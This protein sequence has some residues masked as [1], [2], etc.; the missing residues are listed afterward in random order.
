[1]Q[2]QL[3]QDLQNA[4]ALNSARFNRRILDVLN[5]ENKAHE[6]ALAAVLKERWRDIREG[7]AALTFGELAAVLGELQG[8]GLPISPEKA[9]PPKA[10]GGATPFSQQGF[11]DALRAR[12]LT[13]EGLVL[14]L[15]NLYQ[16]QQDK[17][18][19]LSR[20]FNIFASRDPV[21]KALENIEAFDAH[22]RKNGVVFNE[23]ERDL[24]QGAKPKSIGDIIIELRFA[25]AAAG[26]IALGLAGVDLAQAPLLSETPGL[27]FSTGLP[28]FAGA[29]IGLNIFKAF[30]EYSIVKESSTL[31][32]FAAIT[33]AGFAVSYLAVAGMTGLFPPGDGGAIKEIITEG[34]AAGGFNPMQ[35]M[36]YIVGGMTAFAGIYKAAKSRIE[37]GFSAP[38]KADLK[39]SALALAF[40]R[41]TA[42]PLKMIGDTLLKGAELINKAFPM[43]I[44][45]I[46][47]PAV[48][49]LLSHT[50]ME[51]GLSQFAQYG[52]YYAT[53]FTGLLAG[54]ALMAA[55]YYAMGARGKDFGQIF[56]AYKEGFFISSSSATLPK[57]KIC[58]MNMG[59]REETA[60]AVLPLA[61]VFN[62]YGTSLYLGLTA[63]YGLTMFGND[64][65]FS[66]Y[67]NVA[68]TTFFIAM[69]APGIPASNIALLDPVMQQTGL[70]QS[71]IGKLYAMVL[72]MD[73]LLD[74][75][76]TGMNVMGDMFA[77]VWRDRHV[78][79]ERNRQRAEQ[80]VAPPGPEV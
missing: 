72:P 30:S 15:D 79:R 21:G 47:L 13:V 18:G 2:Q 51:G 52:H 23:A 6:E 41:V 78:L 40:N 46:G 38:D 73:R 75:K 10:K 50:M 62:M 12:E 19:F 55:G 64:P 3:R 8:R 24:A 34:G 31:G 58:L 39:Q 65:G 27:F 77:A 25:L 71:Q 33:A 80:A 53:A 70:T 32:R 68:L 7:R 63:F 26:G 56:S 29:F 11:Y 59:V 36:L 1:M 20:S 48:A 9:A 42:P 37:S 49:T 28:W 67:F 5:Y 74:M 17:K 61:G 60:N 69:G 4:T 22:C 57:E 43:F 16:D 35:Y 14:T 54:T 45:Y 76:Q 44:N 66:E